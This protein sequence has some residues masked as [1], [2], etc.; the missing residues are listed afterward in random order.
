MIYKSINPVCRIH[1]L[2]WLIYPM[3]QHGKSAIFRVDPPC[4][5]SFWRS[6]EFGAGTLGIIT[7]RISMT[8]GATGTLGGFNLQ[9]GPGNERAIAFS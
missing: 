1:A 8:N 4:F 2:F 3:F 5:G 7:R 9:D 6:K